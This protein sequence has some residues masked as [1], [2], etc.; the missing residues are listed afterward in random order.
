MHRQGETMNDLGYRRR[1]GRRRERAVLGHQYGIGAVSSSPL[2]VQATRM[3]VTP[4]L[5]KGR[6]QKANPDR[7]LPLNN[8]QNLVETLTMWVV[9]L[10]WAPFT[11]S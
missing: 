8:P 9:P 7:L 3:K 10:L 2:Y 6:H 5:R 11:T 1:L 4:S